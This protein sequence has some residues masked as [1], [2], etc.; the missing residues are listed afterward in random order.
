MRRKRVLLRLVEAVDLVDEDD[1]AR[2][3][4]PRRSASAIT[5]LTSFMP[6]GTA[7]K[8]R[9]SA[10]R[11]AA[12]SAGQRRLASAGRTPEDHGLQRI[13]A[14]SFRAAEGGPSGASWPSTSSSVRQGTSVPP[15]GPVL[16]VDGRA[17][18]VEEAHLIDDSL[19][20]KVPRVPT[21]PKVPKGGCQGCRCDGHAVNQ[22]V[23]GTGPCTFGN[24]WHLWH[25][26]THPLAPVA[27]LAH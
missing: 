18:V 14:R 1:R 5:S 17:L 10:L 9:K 12:S 16:R 6:K 21:V 13:R 2:P 20:L 19:R 7:L 22:R 8:A 24:L 26:G 4:P 3:A 11:E 15:A 25:L 27:P 23:F